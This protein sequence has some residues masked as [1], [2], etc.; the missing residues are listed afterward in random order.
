ML[1]IYICSPANYH[2]FFYRKM[3]L[4]TAVVSLWIGME[5]LEALLAQGVMAS[6]GLCGP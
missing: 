1:Y 3:T 4:I 2:T 6:R 5:L